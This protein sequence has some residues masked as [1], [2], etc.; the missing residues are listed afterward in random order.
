LKRVRRERRAKVF[1]VVDLAVVHDVSIAVGI[2]HRL[3][4]PFRILKS[5][6]VTT[7]EKACTG[8][9]FGR[10]AIAARAEK[11]ESRGEP[12]IVNRRS[13]SRED[14]THAAHLSAQKPRFERSAVGNVRCCANATLRTFM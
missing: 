2:R 14:S 9:R 4:T 11:L 6:S 5:E 13:E 10:L 1:E 3:A 8:A 7:E 12:G